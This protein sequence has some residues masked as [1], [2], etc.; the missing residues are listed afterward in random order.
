MNRFK[1]QLPKLF[2]DKQRHLAEKGEDHRVIIEEE[3]IIGLKMMMMLMVMMVAKIHL[4]RMNVARSLNPKD[5]RGGEVS[6]HQQLL[7]QKE[8]LR[9]MIKRCTGKLGFY[10]QHWLEAQRFLLGEKVA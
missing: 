8:V 10:Q 3:E 2:V 9:K 6:L 4:L 1:L 7:V 5:Q